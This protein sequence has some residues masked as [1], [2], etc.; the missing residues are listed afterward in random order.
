[1]NPY[2]FF[3]VRL[4]AFG[5]FLVILILTT[6]KMAKKG[7]SSGDTLLAATAASLFWLGGVVPVALSI[8]F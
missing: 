8:F 7:Y 6:W 2:A 1:M 4:F 3:L 5:G